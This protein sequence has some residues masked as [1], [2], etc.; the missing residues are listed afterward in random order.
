M[1]KSGLLLDKLIFMLII[2]CMQ[3]L[4]HLKLRKEIVEVLCM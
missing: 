3:R 4:H 1:F 2:W